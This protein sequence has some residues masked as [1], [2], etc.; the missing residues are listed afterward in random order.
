VE[1]EYIMLFV[2]LVGGGVGIGIPLVKLIN[3]IV[4][5]KRDPLKEAKERL[6][7]AKLEAEA[8][9]LNREANKIT[10]HLYDECLEEEPLEKPHTKA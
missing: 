7:A 4:P 2:L 5:K 8:A 9:K 6:E 10:E 3:A 1:F